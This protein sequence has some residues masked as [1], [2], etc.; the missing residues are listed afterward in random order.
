M[1]NCEGLFIN[2][3]SPFLH[4]EC[5]GAAGFLSRR[6]MYLGSRK[7]E[8]HHIRGQ[9]NVALTWPFIHA[10]AL[11]YSTTGNSSSSAVAKADQWPQ[12]WQWA[13]Q[14]PSLPV[15]DDLPSQG[16]ELPTRTMQCWRK[17]SWDVVA[18]KK[19]GAVRL[20]GRDCHYC[21]DLSKQ[22]LQSCSISRPPRGL[23]TSTSVCTYVNSDKWAVR[24]HS[25]LVTDSTTL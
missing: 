19:C 16:Q 20:L 17:R 14:P 18:E 21:W 23:N 22:L 5:W 25:A 15:P 8:K 9:N 4:F 6:K 7:V 3:V 1:W 12:P 13:A 24:G 10:N 11:D 2:R